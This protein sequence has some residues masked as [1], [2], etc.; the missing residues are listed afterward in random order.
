MSRSSRDD[1]ADGADPAHTED[2]AADPN[3]HEAERQ[4]VGPAT[5]DAHDRADRLAQA[6]RANLRRRKAARAPA[7]QPDGPDGDAR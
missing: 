6:L 2:P 1:T 4:P 7:P 3:P 5:P